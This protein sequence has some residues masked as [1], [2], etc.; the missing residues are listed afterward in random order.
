MV[1]VIFGWRDRPDMTAEECENHYRTVH[2]KLAQAGF[3]GVDG[4]EAVVYDRVR[5]ASVND[6]NRPERR[7]V[8]PD[9]DAFCELYFRDAESMQA[10][11]GRPQMQAMFEDHPN[12]MDTE[13]MSNV[14]IY[15]VD[16]TV[17][18]GKRRSD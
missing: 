10:A 11:F 8:E 4:F 9:F 2:M 1:K 14:R 17:F 15:A 3:D 7:E 5:S 12:F 13:T 18:Y 6:F 16:E